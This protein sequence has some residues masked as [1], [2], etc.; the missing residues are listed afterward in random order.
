MKRD[1]AYFKT[2][3]VDLQETLRTSE[4]E[5]WQC[6]ILAP[7]RYAKAKVKSIE[8]KV[9]IGVLLCLA[10]AV[11]CE[12]APERPVEPRTEQEAAYRTLEANVSGYC[13][14]ACCCGIWATKG[15]NA[16]GQR[17]TASQHVITSD[18]KFVAAPKEYPFGTWMTISG[19]GRVRVEDRGGAIRNN[20]IDLYFC[21]KDGVSGH[22]RALEFG[23]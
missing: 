19:Y 1:L 18:D 21:D 11:G 10:L 3:V 20:K 13:R 7:L 2:C 15:V 16:A 14:R 5:Q 17:V 6:D 8:Q 4:S 23:R 9:G 22:Q 12:K